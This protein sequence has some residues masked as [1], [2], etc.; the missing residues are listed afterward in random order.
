MKILA[1]IPARAKSIRL[2]NKNRLKLGD[3][4]LIK[5][6]IDFVLGT[7]IIKD[8]V[9]STDDEKIINENINNSKIKIFKDL[10]I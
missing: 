6:T 1:I 4:S 10:I 5:W 3:K 2:K 9:L 7:K 8:V